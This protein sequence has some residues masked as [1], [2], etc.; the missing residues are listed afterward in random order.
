[1]R[2]R[3][4]TVIITGA[5]LSPGHEYDVV[6]Q[7]YSA[8]GRIESI[9]DSPR[10]VIMI[11][12]KETTPSQ[13]SG[14]TALGGIVKISLFWDAQTDKDFDVMEVW[15]ATLDDYTL[16]LK[17]ADVKSTSW[18]DN[19]GSTGQTRYY[20]IRARNT[21]GKFSISYPEPGDSGVTATTTGVTATD[22]DDFAVDATKLFTNT[23]IL[24]NDVWTNNSPIGGAIAWNAHSIV[25]NGA[26][27][28]ISAGNT[29]LIYIYWVVGNATY[30]ADDNHP[31]LGSTGFM[32]AVNTAGIRTP[33]WN[34]SANM[35]IGSAF[36]KNAAIVE[37]KIDNLAVTDAKINTLSVAK[38]TTGVISSKTIVLSV[39]EGTG[40]AEILARMNLGDFANAGGNTGFIIGVDDSDGNKPKMYIGSPTKYMKW[41]GA[42][43]TIR[44]TLNADDVTAGTLSV[45][46]L[47][48]TSIAAAK[49]ASDV[50]SGGVIV[51]GL[52]TADNIQ[53]GTLTGR[54]VQT[55]AAGAERMVLDAASNHLAGYNS[56]G[57][58][59]ID[60]DADDCLLRIITA[61]NRFTRIYNGSMEIRSDS[62]IADHNLAMCHINN[63]YAYQLTLLYIDSVTLSSAAA[64]LIEAKVNSVEMFSVNKAGLLNAI[65]YSV[66]GAAGANFNGAVTNI[67]VVDGLVTAAS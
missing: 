39:A 62:D 15:R 32:I 1:M 23:V 12:G 56:A 52:L 33:V 25:Y 24:T 38:L 10:N 40:D 61:T 8:D 4:N 17:V 60:L 66:A 16:A 64:K 20:W 59:T 65:K 42:A 28:P 22:I 48:A 58:L 7:A 44:G 43:L 53:A 5:D 37:A 41:D 54:V 31:A 21:S 18:T 27:Y 57:A 67:T 11:K 63:D 35:V 13:P 47:G 2:T 36:I 46:R 19:I 49:L 55:A 14:L 34:S 50:I 9:D 29:D 51:A 45:N 6:V 26:I 30:S 3:N